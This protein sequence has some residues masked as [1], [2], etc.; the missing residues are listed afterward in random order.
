M[1]PKLAPIIVI[2]GG[3]AGF[4]AAINC[5][6]Q[7]K[8]RP[9]ILLEKSRH[10]LSKVKVSGGGRCNVT[11]A[12]FDVHELVKNY[13]RGATELIAPFHR[14]NPTHTIEW[15]EAK[16]VKLKTEPDGRMFPVTN[17]S[18]TIVNCLTDAAQKLDIAIYTQCGITKLEPPVNER[19][20]W[21]V[22]TSDNVVLQAYK[23][24]IASGSS[25]QMWNLLENLGHHIEPPLPSLFT[26][27]LS[28]NNLL[29]DLAGVTVPNVNIK[30]A[31]TK[32]SATGNLLVT[33]WGISGPAVLRLSAWGAKV[34]H[35]LDYRF[36][37]IINWVNPLQTTEVQVQ[38]TTYKSD[39]S[40][41]QVNARALFNLPM[42]LWKRIAESAQIP[43]TTR[44][45]DVSKKQMQQLVLQ[46]TQT[47]LQATGKSTNKEEFVTC[48][49]VRLSEVNFKTMESKL[50]SRLYFAG[51]V[52]NIDAIT[53]GFNF[54]AA[55][56]CGYIAGNSMAQNNPQ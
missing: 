51:E 46:L 32:L 34:L 25:T 28:H 36:E 26:F 18:Q 10:L 45:A 19:A 30:V 31:K 39:F 29:H 53:G 41:Q 33:H 54:Q 47:T 20:N 52:L 21:Q 49:G 22:T 24:L 13:P 43:E 6:E 16:G 11:H 56:T 7:Q 1:P 8:E 14:F 38:L 40:R 50:L 9:V 3:A 27:N 15:F 42:R 23:V 5:A 12:C 48:G 55:W 44:W 35:D 17:S 4:F 37:V 2:G